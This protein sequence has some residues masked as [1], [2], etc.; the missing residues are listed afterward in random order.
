MAPKDDSKT[1]TTLSGTDLIHGDDKFHSVEVAPSISVSTIFRHPE[2]AILASVDFEP[3][4]VREAKSHLYSR[5]SQPVSSRVESVLSKINGGYA[6][7][8]ASGLAAAFAV[9]DNFTLL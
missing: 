5:L 7:T 2:E 8:Y 3:N 1:P 6:L 4:E 9:C